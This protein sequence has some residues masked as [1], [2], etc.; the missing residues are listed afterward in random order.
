MKLDS[1]TNL[2]SS[3]QVAPDEEFD[4]AA[5]YQG[6]LRT[7]PLAAGAL[8]ILGV[9]VNRLLSG[10]A[11][12]VDA[13]SAQSRADVLVIGLS[14]VLVLTGLQWVSLKPKPLTAVEPDGEVVSFMD[15]KLSGEAK[16][17][18]RWLWRAL[19]LATRCRGV[20]VIH[21]GRCVMHYG[22][23]APGT[24]PGRATVGPI[25]AA[26]MKSGSGNYLANLILFPGRVEFT[27]YFPENTQGV[28]VQPVGEEGLLVC[29]TDTQRGFGRLD[30]AWIAALAEKL[31][32]ALREPE[33]ALVNAEH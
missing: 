11:P 23:A 12:V 13:S 8:G 30:Q 16:A 3:Q 21:K 25:G 6:A 17:E 33:E 5:R 7:V 29:G 19:R 27:E 15:S 14:A 24:V 31:D 4:W 1:I 9:L 2:L 26:A 20:V 10:I 28:L 22:M 32:I 18:L